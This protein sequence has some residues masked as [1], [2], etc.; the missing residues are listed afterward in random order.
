MYSPIIS[1]G[2][3]CRVCVADPSW[4]FLKAER[5]PSIRVT[6]RTEQ[7]IQITAS[8]IRSSAGHCCDQT[9]NVDDH[10]ERR[11]EKSVFELFVS[12]K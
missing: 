5:V 12:T 8:V 4:P 9:A 7:N 3:D 6:E 2:P 1:R 10:P 11:E